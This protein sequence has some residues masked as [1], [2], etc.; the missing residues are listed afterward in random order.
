MT[1]LYLCVE[2]FP[3][4]YVQSTQLDAFTVREIATSEHNVS[5][6]LTKPACYFV[7]LNDLLFGCLVKRKGGLEFIILAFS[8]QRQAL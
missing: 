3:N 7:S 2:C 6:K 1:E 8:V 5:I 4:I